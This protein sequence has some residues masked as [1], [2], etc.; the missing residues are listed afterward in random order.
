MASPHLHATNYTQQVQN[1]VFTMP[2][3]QEKESHSE[4]G[5]DAQ[6]FVDSNEECHQDKHS[7]E[8]DSKKTSI[9]SK[10]KGESMTVCKTFFQERA[11]KA[12]SV[13]PQV[14]H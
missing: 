4:S 14:R 7:K 10:C 11:S 13:S 1:Q 12:A 6:V 8:K 5:A 9:V 2:H 3:R